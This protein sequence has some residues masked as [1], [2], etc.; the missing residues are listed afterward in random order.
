M[1]PHTRILD[2]TRQIDYRGLK[3]CTKS[4]RGEKKGKRDRGREK[5]SKGME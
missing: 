2:E 3:R 5:E 1:N 4:G